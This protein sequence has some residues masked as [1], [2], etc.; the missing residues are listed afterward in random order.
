MCVLHVAGE[1]R[2][3][4][5]A[6]DEL[7][8]PPRKIKLP[9]ARKKKAFLDRPVA[10]AVIGFPPSGAVGKHMELLSSRSG[11][12]GAAVPQWELDDDE[13]D[14]LELEDRATEEYDI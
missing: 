12:R 7:Q 3:A 9:P 8:Q 10:P 5:C 2:G 4:L 14:G 13:F 6:A 11:R 1:G